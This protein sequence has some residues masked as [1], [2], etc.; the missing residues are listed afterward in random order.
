MDWT[1]GQTGCYSESLSPLQAQVLQHRIG[2]SDHRRYKKGSDVHDVTSEWLMFWPYFLRIPL[3]SANLLYE[4]CA[5][6]LN[7]TPIT[8]SDSQVQENK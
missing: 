1:G 6:L 7:L 4:Y 2:R 5:D 8:L 3:G